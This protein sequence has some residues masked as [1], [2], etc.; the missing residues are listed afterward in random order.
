ML[1]ILQHLTVRFLGQIWLFARQ[2]SR[3]GSLGSPLQT[4]D[5]RLF[6][7]VRP[8]QQRQSF[9]L[10]VQIG[11]LDQV[12]PRMFSVGNLHIRGFDRWSEESRLQASDLNLRSSGSLPRVDHAAPEHRVESVMKERPYETD[13]NRSW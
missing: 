1:D 3:V 12:R 7:D 10:R 5:A 6:D 8:L 9:D 13:Q 2:Q 4:R 11:E